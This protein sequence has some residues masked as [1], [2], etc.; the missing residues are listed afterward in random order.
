MLLKKGVV[1]EIGK[2][3]ITV[4]VGLESYGKIP[5]SK[6]TQEKLANL[7]VDDEIEVF[8]YNRFGLSLVLK[9]DTKEDS[10]TINEKKENDKPLEE[11]TRKPKIIIRKKQDTKDESNH[12]N[13]E[14]SNP[15]AALFSEKKPHT[16]IDSSD[17]TKNNPKTRPYSSIADVIGIAFPIIFP[18]AGSIIVSSPSKRPTF[19]P[20]LSITSPFFAILPFN[21]FFKLRGS[22]SEE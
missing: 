1:R 18:S 13:E 2:D 12:K 14:V 22:L 21:S 3:V 9:Q 6:F 10:M 4:D 8:V 20:D 11:T 19:L 15:N 5:A 16:S 17:S 7:K